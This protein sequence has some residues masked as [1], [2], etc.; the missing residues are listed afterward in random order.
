MT[1]RNAVVSPPFIMYYL[2]FLLPEV[3]RKLRWAGFEV[4]KHEGLF[5]GPFA[6]VVVVTA[7]RP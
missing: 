3:E 7:K 1:V 6:R 5:E 2:T 4:T